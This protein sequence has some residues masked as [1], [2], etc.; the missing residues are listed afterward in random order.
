MLQQF[1]TRGGDVINLESDNWRR[2]QLVAFRGRSKNLQELS[3]SNFQDRHAVF[4]DHYRTKTHDIR[5]ER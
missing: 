2:V 5:E 4:G 3:F 1:F